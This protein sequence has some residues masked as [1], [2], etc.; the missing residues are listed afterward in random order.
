MPQYRLVL[1]GDAMNHL[2]YEDMPDVD[3]AAHA[4]CQKAV[5]ALRGGAHEWAAK[6]VR[7]QLRPGSLGAQIRP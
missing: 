1:D 7:V 3:G 2:A 4:A 5:D 6:W